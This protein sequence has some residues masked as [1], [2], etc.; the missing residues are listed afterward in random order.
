MA[1]LQGILAEGGVGTSDLDAKL[2]EKVSKA[3][4]IPPM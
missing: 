4:I 2:Q 1:V 3:R